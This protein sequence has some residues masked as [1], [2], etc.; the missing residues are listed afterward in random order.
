MRYINL[1]LLTYL[2]TYNQTL[3]GLGFMEM[4]PLPRLNFIRGVFRANHLASN[5]NLTKTTKRQNTYNEN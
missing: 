1:R 5:D 3:F 2:L 4:I